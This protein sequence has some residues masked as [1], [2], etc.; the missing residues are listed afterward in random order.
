M[1]VSDKVELAAED[2]GAVAEELRKILDEVATDLDGGLTLAE[3]LHVLA[4]SLPR[5][6]PEL[7]DDIVEPLRLRATLAGN[8]QY[9]SQDPP[10]TGDLPDH[11]FVDVQDW[12]SDVI[13]RIFRRTGTTVTAVHLAQVWLQVLRDGTVSFTDVSGTDLRKLTVEPPPK[14]ARRPRAGDVVSIPHLDGGHHLAVVLTS[15]RIGTALGL[16]MDRTADHRVGQQLRT[17]ARRFPVY[18]GDHLIRSGDWQIV[19]HDEN[20]LA[21][22]PSDPP[23]Y[24]PPHAYQ[25]TGIDT[26]PY[27]AAETAGGALTFITK[28]EAEAVGL[29]DGT[30]RQ[31]HLSEYVQQCLADG[32]LQL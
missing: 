29:T 3:F 23:I 8:K 18:T 2:L 22:F 7:A 13:T 10:R 1:S 11:A 4:W 20:L 24:H 26:G 12:N 14:Q 28:E 31:T 15:N 25:N 21:L 32:S 16:F 30:Y 17:R 9:R 27:G 19:D 5:T 6:S